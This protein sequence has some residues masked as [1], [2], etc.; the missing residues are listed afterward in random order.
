MRSVIILFLDKSWILGAV[1]A[2]TIAEYQAK[3]AVRL[4]VRL[5]TGA[6]ALVKYRII[7]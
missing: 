6:S 1:S 2:K 4:V 3:A 5:E 7:I